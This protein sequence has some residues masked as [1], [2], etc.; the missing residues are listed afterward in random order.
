MNT[1]IGSIVTGVGTTGLSA[2]G[3][4]VHGLCGTGQQVLQFQSLGQVGVPD[5]ATVGG[6]DLGEGLPDL[7]DLLNTY[8]SER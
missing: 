5:H 6:L 8:L 4:R 3:S 7:V 2:D 1:Y